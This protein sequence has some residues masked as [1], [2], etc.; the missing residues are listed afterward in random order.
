MTMFSTFTTNGF[1]DREIRPS[2]FTRQPL[3]RHLRKKVRYGCKGTSID[4]YYR[5]SAQPLTSYGRYA[6]YDVADAPDDH[7]R[8]TLP[9]SSLFVAVSLAGL[10][11][12]QQGKPGSMDDGTI[13][14]IEAQTLKALKEDW[15][16]GLN[17]QFATGDGASENNGTGRTVYG[18][19][20]SVVS[21]PS[22]GTYAGQSRVSISDL[23][24]QQ[25]AA[26]SGPSGAP[27]ADAWWL[28]LSMK[29]TCRKAKKSQ[30]QSY[31]PN[32][33]LGSQVPIED[34][35]NK[36]F[37]QNTALGADVNGMKSL[38]GFDIS[39]DL[40]DD[41]LTSSSVFMLSSNVWNLCTTAGSE[42]ELFKLRTEKN[43][44]FHIHEGDMALVLRSANMQL[45]DEFPKA[46]G[47]ITSW[48]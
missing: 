5:L 1:L 46:N 24:N 40:I 15:D 35:L 44:P 43:L 20:Q 34:I 2:F 45:V 14:N 3:M 23:R 41:D 9:W 38:L 18:V 22:S 10:E 28:V 26:T 30:G 4:W 7:V 36:H 25:F 32:I 29:M 6:T 37:T 13:I 17:P 42:K 16:Y 19:T 27:D 39:D 31:Q 11:L 48:T 12:D 8:L 21:S 33:L 47:M